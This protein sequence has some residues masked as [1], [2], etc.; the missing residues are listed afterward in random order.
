MSELASHLHPLH[1]VCLIATAENPYYMCEQAVEAQEAK[2]GNERLYGRAIESNAYHAAVKRN[3]FKRVNVQYHFSTY[4]FT[5]FM[6]KASEPSG[7]TLALVPP[8]SLPAGRATLLA[9]STHTRPER[10]GSGLLCTASFM[11]IYAVPCS[12]PQAEQSKPR[13]WI[14]VFVGETQ[15][16]ATTESNAALDAAC[17]RCA[18]T[19]T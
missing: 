13:A 3:A 8:P 11:M 16:G 18:L 14:V 15:S 12:L 17:M 19:H 10:S 2:E 6:D 7:S 1:P 4:A 9:P 5:V